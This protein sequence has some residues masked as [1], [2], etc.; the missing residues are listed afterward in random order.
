MLACTPEMRLRSSE[1]RRKVENKYF[2]HSVIG[3]LIQ[4]AYTSKKCL[5]C[6]LPASPGSAFSGPDCLFWVTYDAN[7]AEIRLCAQLKNRELGVR[8]SVAIGL[9]AALQYCVHR[10]KQNG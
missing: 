1:K 7:R 4:A 5:R 9:D 10:C 3:Q 8:S 6:K 2:A